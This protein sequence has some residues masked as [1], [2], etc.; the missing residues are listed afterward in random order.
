MRRSASSSTPDRRR[1]ARGTFVTLLSSRLSPL[2]ARCGRRGNV[3]VTFRPRRAAREPR[4]RLSVLCAGDAMLWRGT[5]SRKDQA[6]TASSIRNARA[7]DQAADRS[8]RVVLRHS[9]FRRDIAVHRPCCRSSPRMRTSCGRVTRIVAELSACSGL[10]SW[11][12]P[13]PARPL[14]CL[15]HLVLFG[16]LVYKA[17]ASIYKNVYKAPRPVPKRSRSIRRA[18]MSQPRLAV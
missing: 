17:F 10:K 15:R 12:F 16:R 1:R 18:P 7:R 6:R 14:R 5:Q 2:T 8:E 3:T 4:E 11:V 9:G 13:Q